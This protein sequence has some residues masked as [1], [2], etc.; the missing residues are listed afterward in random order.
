MDLAL[1]RGSWGF[2]FKGGYERTD[3]YKINNDSERI[4][5]G[6]RVSRTFGEGKAASLAVDF[7]TEKAGYSGLPAFPTPHSRKKSRNLTATLATDWGRFRNNLYYNKGN[8]KN[9]D[10]SRGLDQSLTVVE[11]GDSLTYARPFWKGEL[12]LGAGYEGTAARSSEFGSHRESIAH[13][14]AS[15]SVSLPLSL[16]VRAGIRY[17]LNSDFENT[18]NPELS[19]AFS[20]SAFEAVYK[21]S[22]GVNLP[23]LQQRYN[24]SSSTDPN[25]SL[26]LEKA[27]N[28]SLTLSAFPK[29]GL[30]FS[31]TLFLNR[32]QGRISYVR[33]V[34][35]GIGQYQNIGSAVYM[36]ADLGFSW[37]IAK[38]LELKGSYVYLDA[39]D[40][41][42]D[43][44]LTSLSKNSFTIEASLRPSDDFSLTVKADYDGSTFTDRMNTASLSSRILYSLR[45][46]KS[47]GPFVAFL[48]GVN[49]FDKEYY[50][51]DGLLAPPR[52]YFAGLKYNF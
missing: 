16:T 24:R 23:S 40:K 5:G 8:V 36:G 47:F 43:K 50:Y 19:V 20:K 46:E 45:A 34:D 49:I 10:W 29:D 48:D 44:F 32:L 38:P 15:Q 4:R 18:L 12:S 2:G 9:N 26:G 52:T 17:N 35:S 14:F 22:R 37:R 41:D 42:I 30:S 25:P 7:L 28:Q 3:S 39:R 13:F 11:Y 21:I 51:V 33:P 27:V 31:A 1:S 6:A